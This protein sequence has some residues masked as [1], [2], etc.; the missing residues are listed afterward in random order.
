MIKLPR[1][2]DW[3]ADFI[4]RAG[5]QCIDTTLSIAPRAGCSWEEFVDATAPLEDVSTWSVI[6]HFIGE[7]HINA[8][9]RD[10]ARATRAKISNGTAGKHGDLL[11][12]FRA[13]SGKDP[14]AEYSMSR[15]PHIA[16]TKK[17]IALEHEIADLEQKFLAE[18]ARVDDIEKTINLMNSS[19]EESAREAAFHEYI[20]RCAPNRDIL[21][22]I[23]QLRLK[24]AR[25]YG[26]DSYRD[27]IWAQTPHRMI[28]DPVKFC[29]QIKP[30]LCDSAR[31]EA[32][33]L[34]KS[35]SVQYWNWKSG[36][37][38]RQTD[39]TT[40]EKVLEDFAREF[41]CSFAP[42]D[43]SVWAPD[44]VCF[45]LTLH[46]GR[47]GVVYMDLYPR[48]GKFN[49]AATYLL[50]PP[51]GKYCSIQAVLCSLSREWTTE[52]K[53]TLYHELGHVIHHASMRVKY[54]DSVNVEMDFIEVPARL[55]ER[56][57]YPQPPDWAISELRQLVLAE[58]DLE[59][60]GPAPP[61]SADECAALMRRVFAQTPLRGDV[62][63][64]YA[65]F[66]HYVE[67]YPAYYYC[68][69]TAGIWADKLYKK[70]S[71][72]G[73]CYSDL[74]PVLEIGAKSPTLPA[75]E[76]FLRS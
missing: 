41:E 38:A 32:R 53:V 22:Q 33:A 55:M 64:F 23:I 67:M 76:A 24:L 4:I 7:V 68:Y 59:I 10:V 71:A 3:T 6:I 9:V 47:R 60:H 61:A 49:H 25:E 58:F 20:N 69:V 50:R 12:I 36:I 2:E 52:N 18:C 17:G 63:N 34:Y 75:L 31:S 70:I 19:L 43:A 14:E 13:A 37:P 44:V 28:S 74:V 48:A 51:C 45:T 39:D 40:L 62:G 42:L 11:D 54:R 5:Q 29:A 26:F 8:D 27:Y 1:W 21:P 66:A 72:G 56:Y 57:I 30:T 16:K 73:R 46:D 65:S 35:D 15:V